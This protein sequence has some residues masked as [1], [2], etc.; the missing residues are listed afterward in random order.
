MNMRTLTKMMDLSGRK[1]L[2]TG[3]AGH[4]GLAVEESLIE[5]GASLSVLDIDA[6]A[7]NKRVELLSQIRENSALPIVCDLGD[8][9]STREAIRE[10]VSKLGGLDILVHCAAYV[11]TTNAPGWAVP[12]ENQS[13]E[14]WNA[15]IQVNLTSP[16]VMTQEARDALSETGQGSIILFGSIYGLSGPDMRL[17]SGTEMENPAGYGASKGGL[18]QLTRHLA[19]ILAPRIRVNAISPGGVWREQPEPF[20]KRYASRTPLGRLAK[21]EDLK[22]AVAYLASVLSEYV[23]GHNL[24]IDGGWT[25]W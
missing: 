17:Y 21:E 14:A 20:P 3:G 10:T 7:C 12:F 19:T 18:L 22:G 15:A 6:E 2:V 1:A 9:R 11:G 24:V 25:T 4:I 13:V 16:F 8:E 23:T 5:L